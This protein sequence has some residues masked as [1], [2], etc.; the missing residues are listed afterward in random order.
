MLE[1]FR[2]RFSTPQARPDDFREASGHV[3]MVVCFTE[4]DPEAVRIEERQSWLGDITDE[5]LISRVVVYPQ[6]VELRGGA[7]DGKVVC[8]GFSL[9][10]SVVLAAFTRVDEVFWQ[11]HAAGGEDDGPC[12]SIEGEY[13]G[14]EVWLR[15]L[16]SAPPGEAPGTV[17]DAPEG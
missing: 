14:R 6:P 16:A 17:F 5:C 11:A 4:G 3:L 7:H 1:G 10:L 9:E 8:P 2:T 15:V 12:I 13:A